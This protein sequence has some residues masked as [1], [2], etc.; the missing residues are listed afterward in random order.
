[1]LL[2]QDGRSRDGEDSKTNNNDFLH[3]SAP[4]KKTHRSQ[5][6]TLDKGQEP[7]AKAS[8]GLHE[9]SALPD[10]G[11]RLEPETVSKVARMSAA[12]CGETEE[13]RISLSLS[14]GAHSRDPVLTYGDRLPSSIASTVPAR[15]AGEST[16]RSAPAVSSSSQDP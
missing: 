7:A 8:R 3:A 9:L 5:S 15:S 13:P 6:H 2:S 4:C 16:S 12:I 1:V 10:S 14:S 11:A